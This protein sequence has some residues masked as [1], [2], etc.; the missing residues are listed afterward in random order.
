M[1]I[2]SPK[3]FEPSDYEVEDYVDSRR[4]AYYGGGAR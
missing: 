3:H 2:H 4:P 1:N